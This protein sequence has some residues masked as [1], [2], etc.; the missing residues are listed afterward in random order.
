MSTA[1][2]E[3]TRHPAASPAGGCARQATTLPE[4]GAGATG[5]RGARRDA[6]A[7]PRPRLAVRLAAA[8]V[9]AATTPPA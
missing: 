6:P 4:P 8:L 5:D 1:I 2:E 3:R 9:A 7:R